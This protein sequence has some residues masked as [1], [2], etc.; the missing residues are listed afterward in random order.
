M[1]KLQ[2]M[3]NNVEKYLDECRGMNDKNGNYFYNVMSKPNWDILN[4]FNGDPKKISKELATYHN[5][6]P[7]SYSSS[8][9]VRYDENNVQ[10]IKALIVGPK[11]TP[12]ENGC[13]IFHILCDDYPNKCPKI[14]FEKNN[15]S[16]GT[17]PF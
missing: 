1:L 16:I 12:Y 3:H 13:F 2:T 5:S 14:H 6:L 4:C 11:D 15:K 9:F 7:L 8:V 10:L 17:V